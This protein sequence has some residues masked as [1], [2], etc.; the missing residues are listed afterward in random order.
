[1]AT[2]DQIEAAILQLPPE[3]FQRLSEW[4][5]ELDQQRWDAELE[6][7]IAAGKLDALAEE[8]IA[9]FKA[10]RCRCLAIEK[11]RSLAKRIL[12]MLGENRDAGAGGA[13]GTTTT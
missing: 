12:R 4:I 2:I 6:D 5:L 1:M 13:Q 8:A 11:S 3:D 7:D 10:G 9:D